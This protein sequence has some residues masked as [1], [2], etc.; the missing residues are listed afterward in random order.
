MPNSAIPSCICLHE[1]ILST[2]P[3]IA[4]DW[5]ILMKSLLTDVED[6]PNIPSQDRTYP[7]RNYFHV[8]NPGN[9]QYLR[10]IFPSSDESHDIQLSFCDYPTRGV[11]KRRQLPHQ[12]HLTNLRT[13]SEKKLLCFG[14]AGAFSAW[15]SFRRVFTAWEISSND[16]FYPHIQ[17]ERRKM[18]SNSVWLHLAL[19]LCVVLCVSAVP[20]IISNQDD[21]AADD[22]GDVDVVTKVTRVPLAS[23]AEMVSTS[24]AGNASFPTGTAFLRKTNVTGTSRCSELT[25]GIGGGM[26]SQCTKEGERLCHRNVVYRCRMRAN[27]PGQ[28]EAWRK[29]NKRCELPCENNKGIIFSHGQV[30]KTEGRH[31]LKC[32]NAKFR[33]MKGKK[34]CT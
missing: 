32:V 14:I 28:L 22:V 20:I 30:V 18:A 12:C 26:D 17:K 29:D 10:I 23:M 9:R 24:S 5:H 7:E 8:D 33:K 2:I 13:E 31:C 4:F 25:D 27:C 6:E 19:G 21:D 3:S 15:E 1:T 34:N 11:Y 16:Q